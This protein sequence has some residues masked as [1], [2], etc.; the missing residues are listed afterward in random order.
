MKYFGTDGIRGIVGEFITEDLAYRVGRALSELPNLVMV[1]GRDTR[2]SGAMLVCALKEGAKSVGIDVCDLGVV[3]TPMLSYISMHQGA[4]GVMITA[5]HN[6]YTDNGI[7]V[8]HRGMKLFAKEE[9]AMEEV[10]S[11]ERTP[12]YPSQKGNDLPAIDAMRLYMHLIDGILTPTGLRIA[13]DTANGATTDIAPA[14]FKNIVRTPV[15]TGNVPNGKNINE[16]VGSTHLEN[17]I[18]VVKDFGFLYG[19][20][21]DGDG[22]R[23]MVVDDS[24]RVYDGDAL[25]YIMAMYL[26]KKNHLADSTVVL[27]SMSNLGVIQAF[28]RNNIKVLLTDVGD[29]NVLEALESKNL[30][31]GGE[32]SGHIINRHLLHTG[33]G[34]LN[35]V[36]L[37]KILEE[38]KKSL[39]ELCSDLHMFPDKTVNL[40]NVDKTLAKHPEVAALKESWSTYFGE[41]GKVLVRASGTEPVIR[42]TV[43]A[44]TM[45]ILEKCQNEIIDLIE[46]LNKEH[47]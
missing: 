21:F 11:G 9:Q 5:S 18:N 46:R 10:I 31:I 32:N 8:F 15:Y 37:I 14:V 3:S 16:H 4:I 23:I 36:Y 44:P 34:I 2:E 33:D 43:S 1:I 26:K 38:T 28:A 40:R 45:E 12:K 24:G 17:I 13:F 7:K 35:A 6:P 19:M 22:D 47:K 25:I 42:V 29:K 41:N 30:T 27:T 39:S 20:A